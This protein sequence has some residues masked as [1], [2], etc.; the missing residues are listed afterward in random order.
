MG[1][2][3][4]NGIFTLFRGRQPLLR[5]IPGLRSLT[6][7]QR[8]AHAVL[9]MGFGDS[10]K[11]TMTDFVAA[12]L[13]FLRGPD[14][15]IIVVRFSGGPNAGHNVCDPANR[16]IC[17]NQIPSGI[18]VDGVIGFLS[19]QMLVNPERL[20]T[21]IEKL[22]GD[23]GVDVLDRIKI[24]NQASLIMP[25]HVALN[26]MNEVSLGADA[27]GS[28]GRGMFE[29]VK[30][31]DAEIDIKVADLFNEPVLRRKLEK[32][33]AGKR[34]R[35]QEIMAKSPQARE[36]YHENH[37]DLNH[38]VSAYTT[39]GQLFKDNIV[40][41]DQVDFVRSEHKDGASVVFENSQGALLDRWQGVWPY[42]TP[43]NVLASSIEDACDI[44][45]AEIER[46]GV[47]RAYQTRHARG[48][49]RTRIA[50][51][52]PGKEGLLD[53][54]EW[55]DWPGNFQAGWL[56]L[57]LLQYAQALNGVDSLAITCVDRL[58]GFDQVK[59]YRG[60]GEDQALRNPQEF[61]RNIN[62]LEDNKDRSIAPLTT[63]IEQYPA[64]ES[65]YEELEGWRTKTSGFT[66]YS[67]FPGT[68]KRFIR[69]IG[70]LSEINPVSVV[71]VGAGRHQKIIL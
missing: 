66:R 39:L 19:R 60:R 3:L 69:T 24:S 40:N 11:G 71:S 55:N 1:F 37:F 68:L 64:L 50:N 57:P 34:K 4:N 27:R 38:L 62:P 43:T 31:R 52:V 48:P 44:P 42:A 18:L 7:P 21:E 13:R 20:L 54:V 8:S 6:K 12:R 41:E 15:K 32:A 61:R 65:C 35:A 25:F 49:L 51:G 10:G 17:F 63:H 53:S 58:D 22:K 16:R 67:Q 59:L 14:A 28:I 30:D 5:H 29:A 45:L 26:R 23:Y 70:D 36:H 46:I 2:R 33:L 56:D 9:D 47:I